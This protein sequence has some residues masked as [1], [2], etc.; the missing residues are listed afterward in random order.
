MPCHRQ[1]HRSDEHSRSAAATAHTCQKLHVPS[2][3]RLWRLQ[4][5][6]EGRMT[7][8]RSRM[9]LLLL[10][11]E[12]GVWVWGEAGRQASKGPAL[13]LLGQGARQAPIRA[14]SQSIC[15]T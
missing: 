12:H 5:T 1:T 14:G 3:I 2:T 15:T 6:S 4:P 8:L 7:R 10:L 13:Q 11:Q 9:L